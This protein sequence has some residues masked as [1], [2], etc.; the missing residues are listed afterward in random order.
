MGVIWQDLGDGIIETYG[1]YSIQNYRYSNEVR[2]E[3]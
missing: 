3:R 2:S 1:V